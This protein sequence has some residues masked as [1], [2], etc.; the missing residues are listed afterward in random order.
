MKF[1]EDFRDQFKMKLIEDFRD[2]FEGGE[3]WILGTG[4]SGDDFPL[5]FFDDKIS[6]A[7][8]PNDVIFPNC[9][10]NF[11]SWDDAWAPRLKVASSHLLSK[12]IFTL[13]P[14]HR[15]NFLD[16]NIEIPIFMR[17]LKWYSFELSKE[18]NERRIPEKYS[19]ESV[20]QI[21]EK[22]SHHYCGDGLAQG[23]AIEAALVL[24]AKKVTLVGCD[25]TSRK[26]KDYAQRLGFFYDHRPRRDF[27]TVLPSKNGFS[28]EQLV[29][30]EKKYSVYRRGQILFAKILKSY[31]IELRKYFYKTRYQN[32][33]DVNSKYLNV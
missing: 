5:D 6:I 7:I 13:N 1:I 27:W 20:K 26:H 21:I 16:K 28:K 23:W 32:I 10:Y 19:E 12:Q 4:P 24:G 33:I 11:C 22:N 9:T 17:T 15:E 18:R 31:G 25:A 8:R 29:L 30:L 3:I 2:Q 14:R